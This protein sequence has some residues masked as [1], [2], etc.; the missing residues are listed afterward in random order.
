MQNNQPEQAT[1]INTP[2]VIMP[3][4]FDDLIIEWTNAKID[5]FSRV[6]P[7]TEIIDGVVIND[8]DNKVRRRIEIEMVVENAE[9]G[10]DSIIALI[11]DI[12]FNNVMS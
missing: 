7:P 10:A 6:T 4:Q 2:E 5:N 8:F 11:N 3:T 9:A 1:P 12:D